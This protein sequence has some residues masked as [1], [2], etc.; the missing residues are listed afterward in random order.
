MKRLGLLFVAFI[1]ISF[2]ASSQS[3]FQMGAKVGGLSTWLINS[4]ILS[5]EGD[6]TY[7]AAIGYTIGVNGSFYFNGRSYYSHTLKGFSI[8]L[9]YSS[10]RQAY[11]TKGNSLIEP[12]KHNVNLSYIDLAP[13]L[14]IQPI[15][16]DGAYFLFGPQVSFW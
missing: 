9:S 3:V 5:G 7:N 15:A 8:E 16:D 4:R 12:A 13:M 1:A 10:I 6:T 11:K 2:T 14:S